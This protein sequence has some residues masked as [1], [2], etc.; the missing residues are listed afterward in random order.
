MFGIKTINEGT[1]LFKQRSFEIQE[2]IAISKANVTEGISY[3]VGNQTE[4]IQVLTEGA[5]E[6]AKGTLT[7]DS[8]GK[9]VSSAFKG[10]KDSRGD[11]ICIGLCLT[12]RSCELLAEILV[13]TP[14]AIEITVVS[15]LKDESYG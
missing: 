3:I 5:V 13:W 4:A 7:V 15:G 11:L 1:K 2:E 9:I 6:T 14:I 10:P 8:C 12:S